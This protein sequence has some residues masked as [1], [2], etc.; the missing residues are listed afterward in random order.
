[1]CVCMRGTEMWAL[2]LVSESPCPSLEVC[3]IP[4]TVNGHHTCRRSD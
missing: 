4:S 1:V 3:D 2:G